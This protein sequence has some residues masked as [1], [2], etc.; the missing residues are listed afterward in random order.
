MKKIK[1]LLMA[2][3][4]ALILT[5]VLSSNAVYAAEGKRNLTYQRTRPYSDDDGDNNI[6]N[7]EYTFAASKDGRDFKYSIVKIFDYN[8]REL[9]T[10]YKKFPDSFYCIRGGKGFGSVE[11]GNNS[12]ANSTEYTVI[13]DMKSNANDVIAKYKEL[14]QRNKTHL[15]NYLYLCSIFE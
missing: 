10:P 13:E 14:S 12:S 1:I 7:E 4:V 6:D 8:K 5:T 3:V 9:E 2:L 15:P 11:F